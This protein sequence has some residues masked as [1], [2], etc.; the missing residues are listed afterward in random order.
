MSFGTE[1]KQKWKTEEMK[2]FTED[3]WIDVPNPENALFW[4]FISVLLYEEN[5]RQSK[6]DKEHIDKDEVESLREV[7]HI[8]FVKADAGHSTIWAETSKKPFDPRGEV[9]EDEDVEKSKGDEQKL[10]LP[11]S[12]HLVHLLSGV[13]E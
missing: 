7:D 10:S 6:H 4:Q 13:A 5:H 3:D 1:F 12:L 8:P 2:A 9:A 11:H